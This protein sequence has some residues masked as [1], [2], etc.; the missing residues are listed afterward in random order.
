MNIEFNKVSE[1]NRGTIFEL[2]ADAYS[3]DYRC[4][5]RWSS[6]WKEFDN[7]FFDNLQIADKYGFI[8][9]LNNEAIGMISWDPR[10]IP[11]YIEIGHNCIVSKYKNNGYGKI[12]LQ[13]AYRRIVLNDV[14]RIIVT[15]NVGL[16]PAQQM[17]EGV[18]FKAYN[19]RPNEQISDFPGDY[20]DYVIIIKD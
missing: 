17:Y 1:F 4:A 11:D 16:F 2:L 12:Q 10:N 15:T 14:N 18:G 7:F 6:D 20:I 5:Q 8:T 13:E 3:F 19:R 9:T